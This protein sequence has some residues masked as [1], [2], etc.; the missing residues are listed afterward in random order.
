M[1]SLSRPLARVG[2]SGRAQLRSSPTRLLATALA[3]TMYAGLTPTAKVRSAADLRGFARPLDSVFHIAKSE[4]RNQVHYGVRVDSDCRLHTK[5]PVY[6]YWRDLEEGPRVTSPLLSREQPA[7]GLTQPRTVANTE[8]GG[9]VLIGLRGF[10][11]R[12]IT[13][14]TFPAAD[15]KCRAWAMTTV[16]KAPAILSSIYVELGFLFSIDFVLMRGIHISDKK[17]V[18]EKVED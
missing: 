15:G 11:D 1:A 3:M 13:I 5:T 14:Q 17:P 4:N 9:R 2:R 6:G 16:L 12:D 10:P 8:Q 7:Y 18:Q